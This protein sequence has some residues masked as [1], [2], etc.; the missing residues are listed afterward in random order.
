VA[1]H[2]DEFKRGTNRFIKALVM[3]GAAAMVVF[4]AACGGGGTT[5]TTPSA[6]KPHVL[7]IGVS[8][9]GPWTENFNPF[10]NNGNS[11][12]YGTDGLL[13]ETLYFWDQLDPSQT[14][15]LLAQS[16]QL[17]SDGTQATFHLQTGVKWSDGQAFT[18]ADVVF[19]INYSI[20]YASL[21]VD[22]NGLKGFVKSVTATDANTVV[23]NFT[24]PAATNLWYLA[25][26]TYIVPQHIWS[27]ITDPDKE[28]NSNPV[29]TGPFTLK[30]F[31][32]S[33][34]KLAKNPNYW[35]PGK[36]QVDEVD[37]PSFNSNMTGATLLAQSQVDWTG[38]F[39]ADI[40]DAY[41]NHNP[42]HNTFYSPGVQT[43]MLLPNLTN[44]ILKD[45]KV[46]QALSAAIDRDQL[47]KVAE[48]GYQ[49]VASPTGLVLPAF[50][51]FLDP[52]Y[53][54]AFGGPQ[55]AQA[56]SIL[57]G[58]GYTLDS[59]GYFAKGGKELEFSIM[60]PNGWSDWNQMETLIATQEKAAGIKIDVQE[61][62]QAD[63]FTKVGNGD[64]DLSL[65]W[66][67]HGP[68]PY[69]MYWALLDSVNSAAIGKNANSNYQRWQDPQTDKDLLTI[70]NT[71]DPTVAQTAYNDLQKIMVEQVPAIPLVYGSDWN[72]STTARFTGWSSAANPYALPAPF[73]APD[74]EITVLHLTP[75][76]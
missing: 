7:T 26:Q 48:D 69:Y 67:N 22:Q 43:T 40:Q 59:N 18:S 3:L 9:K 39:I 6:S 13:Y 21:G 16:Y 60:A 32:P 56:K 42:A 8:P 53:P 31:S 71:T 54:S 58:D 72:E 5:G 68:S 4:L 10:L 28:I 49:S 12:L 70:A 24:G 15:P 52:S 38:L 14:E 63:W 33:I 23:V 41:I 66:T 57:Q 37:Y 64:F 73:D 65:H 11:N 35:Q 61:P 17:S 27:S 75:A 47:N 19:S 44:P 55:P 1:S 76:S 36:P 34:Y 46:R 30:S 74:V 29:G 45:V 25:G 2:F 50:K 62:A 20:Q 51:T